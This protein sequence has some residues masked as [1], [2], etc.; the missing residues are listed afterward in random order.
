MFSS[1]IGKKEV[2]RIESGGMGGSSTSSNTGTSG[3]GVSTNVSSSG[4][5]GSTTGG[6]GGGRGS[7]GEELS[8]H[9]HYTHQ[10]FLYPEYI[11]FSNYHNGITNR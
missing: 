2:T 7:V 10:L 1:G 3:G 5:G 4:G 6:S 9:L 11:N 8:A